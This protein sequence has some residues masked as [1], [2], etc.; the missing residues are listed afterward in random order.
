MALLRSVRSDHPGVG[1]VLATAYG[2]IQHAIEAMRAGADDYLP[3]PFERQALLLTVEKALKA[4]ALSAENQRLSERLGEREKLVDLV[5]ITVHGK[6][7]HVSRPQLGAD[8]LYVAASLVTQIQAIVTRRTNPVEPVVIGVGKLHAGTT[9]NALAE[10]AELEGTT[11]TV[12]PESRILVRQQITHLAEQTAEAFG[13]TVEVQ[14]REFTPAVVNPPAITEE[15]AEIARRIDDNIQVITQRP[16]SLGGD[17]FADLALRVPGVYAFLGTGNPAVAN[18]QNS[19]HN[20]NFD[21]DEAALPI[22]AALY[23]DYAFWWLTAGA[24]AL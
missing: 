4:R 20:G 2:S 9:Y 14:W 18:T 10:T 7:A 12:T 19:H 8:A 5:G 1:F 16:I 17:N 13:A 21:L 15:V 24:A 11:R 6:G 23:A 22:G 3:K